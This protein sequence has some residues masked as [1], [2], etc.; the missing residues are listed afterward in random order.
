MRDALHGERRDQNR[1]RDLGPEDGRRGGDL[2]DVHEHARAEL[3]LLE[4][5]EVL[6]QRDLV[7]RAAGKVRVRICVELVLRQ[8]LVI[9]D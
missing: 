4:C 8:A 9:P 2:A 7:P 6:A 3:A 1:Q 5:S